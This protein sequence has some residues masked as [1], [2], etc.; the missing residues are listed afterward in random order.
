M[1][2]M[3][4]IQPGFTYSTCRPFT[5][6]KERI[7]KFKE[8]GDSRYIYQN[9]L[10]KASF[11]HDVVYGEFKDFPRRTAV[12]NNIAKSLKYDGYQRS[13]VSMVYKFFD[14]KTFRI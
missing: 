13:L 5:K 9:Q 7:K 2:E 12:D 14:K 8:I 3:H 1:S 11:Q 4:L 6:N 10:N